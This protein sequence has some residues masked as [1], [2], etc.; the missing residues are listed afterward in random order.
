MEWQWEREHREI[1]I[2]MTDEHRDLLGKVGDS[3]GVSSP[4]G[5]FEGARF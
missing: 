1:G 5:E 3:V 2:P 4:F